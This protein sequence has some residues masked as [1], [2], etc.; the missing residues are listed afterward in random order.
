[1]I[2]FGSKEGLTMI[3]TTTHEEGLLGENWKE[4][5]EEMREN[6]VSSEKGDKRRENKDQAFP[7]LPLN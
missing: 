6:L 1:M 7:I 2:A 3:R 5:T 4:N